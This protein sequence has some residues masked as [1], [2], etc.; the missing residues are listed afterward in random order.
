M[1]ASSSNSSSVDHDGGSVDSTHGHNNTRHVLVA[2]GKRDVG[3]V[4][5]AT[6]D[7]LNRVGDD[8]AGLQGVAHTSGTVG[9]AVTDTDGVELHTLET[10]SF[11][12]LVDLV[13]EVHQVHVAGVSRV[14]DGRDTDLGLVHVLVVEASGVQH[15]LRGTVG[16][17][18]GDD[19][20]GLVEG[21]LVQLDVFEDLVLTRAGGI[22]S[23]RERL[24]DR[25]ADET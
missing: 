15:G 17:G 1:A 22:L 12:T 7:S 14:P 21:I 8:V 24:G 11:N 18:L 20:T 3:V 25:G 2:T 4:P 16:L 6:H 23:G 5:L 10:S 9:H 13:A 19:G